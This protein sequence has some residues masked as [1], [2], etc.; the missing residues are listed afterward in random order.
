M[1]RLKVLYLI[2]SAIKPNIFFVEMSLNF[3][4]IQI[5]SKYLK[6]EVVAMTLNAPPWL[7]GMEGTTLFHFRLANHVIVKLDARCVQPGRCWQERATIFPQTQPPIS[8]RA[9]LRTQAYYPNSC[10]NT[11]FLPLFQSLKMSG[12]VTTFW[13]FNGNRLTA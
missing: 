7:S 3:L 11:R 9:N 8:P 13:S 10:V 2:F 5:P 12:K 1:L 4:Y 6:I